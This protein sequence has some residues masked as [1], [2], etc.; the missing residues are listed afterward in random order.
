MDVL[1]GC[2]PQDTFYSCCCGG[3]VEKFINLRR[4]LH[5]YSQVLLLGVSKPPCTESLGA[6]YGKD[7]F[8]SDYFSS[9]SP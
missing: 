9:V 3:I 5:N 1:C 4:E 6:T 2:D 7:K 8:T